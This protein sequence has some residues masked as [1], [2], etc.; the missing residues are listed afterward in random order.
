MT[1]IGA[2]QGMRNLVQDRLAD[3]I[4]SVQPSERLAEPDHSGRGATYPG[5]GLG[6]VEGEGP[7]RQA[8]PLDQLS[9]QGGGSIEFHDDPRSARRPR[10]EET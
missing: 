7:A 4:I 1:M 3:F 2:D 10:H 6:V 9:R 8:V 5:P